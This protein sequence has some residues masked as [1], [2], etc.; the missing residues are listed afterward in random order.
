MRF[1]HH[2]GIDQHDKI[3]HQCYFLSA[4]MHTVLSVA[5]VS[6]YVMWVNDDVYTGCLEVVGE[7]K[8]QGVPFNKE[9]FMLAFATCYKLVK[10][11]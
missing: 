6:V 9:T 7:M 8:K 5:M 2:Q 1:I 3:L 10:A 4:K 11:M